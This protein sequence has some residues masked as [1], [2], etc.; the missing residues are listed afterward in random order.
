MPDFCNYYHC[1]QKPKL[2]TR[3]INDKNDNNLHAFSN[4]T[5]REQ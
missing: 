5:G 1:V 3:N 2:L 4:G